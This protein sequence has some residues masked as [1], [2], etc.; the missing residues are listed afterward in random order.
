MALRSAE[1]IISLSSLEF[2][3]LGRWC[4]VLLHC[5]G[6]LAANSDFYHNA[7]MRLRY[8]NVQECLLVCDKS[9]DYYIYGGIDFDKECRL[10]VNVHSFVICDIIECAMQY[11]SC[12][13]NVAQHNIISL[14]LSFTQ[15][16]RK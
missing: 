12:Q 7:Y 1:K 5:A 8:N 11:L 16:I 13:M 10:Q 3:L 4:S 2:Y 14:I 15:R 6:T 9:C